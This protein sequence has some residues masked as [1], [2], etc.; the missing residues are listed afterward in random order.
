MEYTSLHLK[1]IKVFVVLSPIIGLLLGIMSGNFFTFLFCTWL[2]FGLPT[3][4]KYTIETLEKLEDYISSDGL[5]WVICIIGFPIIL[6]AL[7]VVPFSQI[8][9]IRVLLHAAEHSC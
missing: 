2:A 3:A 7:I 9:G 5:I 4:C 8:K 1:S 6:I